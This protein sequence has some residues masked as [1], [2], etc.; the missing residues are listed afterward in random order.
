MT[1]RH[2]TEYRTCYKCEQRG[3][4]AQHPLD[5]FYWRANGTPFSARK[6]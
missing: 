4:P 3:L 1:D 5:H 6:A 2:T